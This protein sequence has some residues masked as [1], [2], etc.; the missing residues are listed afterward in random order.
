MPDYDLIII[1]GGS[2]GS[3]AGRRAAGSY[4]KKVCVIERGPSR[5]EAGIRRGGGYGGTC[6]NVGCVPKKLMYMASQLRE[7]IVGEIATAKGN[8]FTIPESAGV[9][10]WPALKKRRD[11]YVAQLNKNYVTNWKKEGI[12]TLEGVGALEGPTS[13][14]VALN[15]GGSKLITADRV[16]VAVGGKPA[17]PDIPGI[18]LAISSDSFFDLEAQPK[19]VA[20]FGAGYIAVE[21]AGILHGLG[22][23]SHLFFRGET[24]MR[25]GFDPYIVETLMG[26]MTRCVTACNGL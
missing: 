20:T 10:D 1:G 23:E 13:V 16:L 7:S 17:M 3:A 21:M 14:R 12:D 5:D 4:G 18:E 9:C 25:N 2:G 22:S 19:K 15:G 11:A 6:V 8:G 26:E 24:V